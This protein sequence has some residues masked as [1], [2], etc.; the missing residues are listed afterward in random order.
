MN[1]P[2]LEVQQVGVQRGRNLLYRDFDCTLSAGEC[3]W[4]KGRNGGGK[5]SL[6][7]TLCGL[8]PA[9][10]GNVL[11]QG[12]TFEHSGVAL[13][14]LWYFCPHQPA[15][16]NV[17]TLAENFQAALALSNTVYDPEQVYRQAQIWGIAQMLDRP[18]RDLSQGQRRRATFVRLSLLPFRPVWLLDEPFDAL[19]TDA[20]QLLAD[21]M[22]THLQ[23]NGAIL[24]T[25][26]F[27]PP[28][29]LNIHREI[30][31]AGPA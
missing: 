23:Q 17:W 5:T 29:N 2:L 27:Q 22:N 24:M 18:A 4:L 14:R 21:Y 12:Q 7:L 13:H 3:V 11:W 9:H 1:T 25:S 15:L 10:S 26:H 31:L 20:Q 6:M 30:A 19:D 28:H 8:L 16:K